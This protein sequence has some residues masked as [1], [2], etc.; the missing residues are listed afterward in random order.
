MHPFPVVF[1]SVDVSFDLCLCQSVHHPCSLYLVVYALSQGPTTCVS[2][3]CFD[4]S[5]GL[6]LYSLSYCIAAF[7]CCLFWIFFN[8]LFELKK[9]SLSVDLCFC[10]LC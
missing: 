1:H 6:N 5:L 10:R 3:L 7:K 2:D 4:Q 8:I 9:L